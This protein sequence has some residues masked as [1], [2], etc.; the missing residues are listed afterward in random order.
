MCGIVGFSWKDEQLVRQ[1]GK[2]LEHRG[3]DQQGTYVDK[4]VSL[5]H[6][7]LSII[8]LSEKGRQP[9]SNEDGT[10]WV[11][12]NGEIY[13]FRELRGF[14]EGK[15]HRFQ[16]HCDTEVIVHAYEE[17][18]LECMKYFNGMFTFAIWDLKSQ[19]LV[20]ARDR[21]GIKPLYFYHKGEKF[22]FASEIKAILQDPN[23]DRQ[24]DLQ[25]LVHYMGFEFVPA[26]RT[27][28]HHI[29]KLPAGH[30]LIYEKGKISISQYWDLRFRLTDRSP[31][32][33]ADQMLDLL[34]HAVRKRLISDV[35]LG[36]FLSG[37]LDS[38]TVVALMHRCGISPLQ[39]F[40]LGYEDPSFSELDYARFMAENV[41]S[42][43]HEMIIEPITPSLIEKAA[44]H[45]DEPMTDLSTIS[46]YLICQKAKQFATVCLSGEG[47]DEVLVGYDR[48]KASK[49]HRYYEYVPE[50]IRRGIVAPLV[51]AL[52][53]QS[54]KKG[55]V[56][57]MKR[58]I[59]GGL[60]PKDG[61]H[62]RW[63]YFGQSIQEEKL[64]RDH[65]REYVKLDPFSLI[66][67][68]RV[69]CNSEDQLDQEIYVDLKFT[70][71]ESVLMKVDKM[72]M[73]HSLEVRVPFLDHEFVEFCATIPS[74]FKLDGFQTKAIFRSAMKGVLPEKIRKRGKQGYS[75]P[76][77]NWLRGELKEYMMDML[78][79]SALIR[80]MFNPDALER[81][82]QQHLSCTHNRNHELWALLNLAVWHKLFLETS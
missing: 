12:Y 20:L 68:Y 38:S 16:S 79:E 31:Q 59:Q 65:Y 73:A 44:W 13:N 55:P 30:Y 56:N 58:F 70:M 60:L 3:P 63:Q 64:L 23:V 52:P 37:G 19:K 29:Q 81:M 67:D 57:I 21:L 61:G 9:M 43:H 15:G 11:T 2:V 17:F 33:Y 77:K 46:F 39:T 26:P 5:G 10:V 27:M 42:Q 24:I 41:N 49:A 22:I 51:N 48:F 69:L 71:A 47:G 4:H 80:N 78:H 25:S 40:A 1:M 75:L 35:P 18:G 36:V 7:R 62:I 32:D 82:I 34:T 54:Q 50:W 74:S 72:S 6:R 14:L 45:L 8:D 53:D 28:F 66:R 76:I